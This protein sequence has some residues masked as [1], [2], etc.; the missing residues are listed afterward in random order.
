MA[1]K[2]KENSEMTEINMSV[3]FWMHGRLKTWAKENGMSV[4][5]AIRYIINQFFKDKPV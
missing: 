3:N 4:R 1:K 5:A 2:K